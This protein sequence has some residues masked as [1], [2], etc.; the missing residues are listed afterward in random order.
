MNH[1]SVNQQQAFQFSHLDVV[2][3]STSPRRKELLEQIGV[4]FTT[5]A[6]DIDESVITGETPSEYVVRLAREKALTAV[7]NFSEQTVIIAADTTVTIDGHILGKPVNRE[8]AFAMWELL[9]GRTHQVMTGVAVAFLGQVQTAIVQTDVEF[10]SLTHEQMQN[11]WDSGEPIGKAGG[12]AIQGLGAVF[13]PRIQGSYS[14]VVGLPL[15]ET[16]AL[17]TAVTGQK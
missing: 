17:I 3:A 10:L 1:H 4:Q 2:L 13:V 16:V 9:S 12:Y 8:D 14:N 6:I 5:T 11:Y 15:V 7:S